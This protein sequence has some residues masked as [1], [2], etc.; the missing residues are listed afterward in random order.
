MQKRKIILKSAN[1]AR[2]VPEGKKY[3]NDKK[4]K[5]APIKKKVLKIPKNVKN[6]NNSKSML[7][8]S[9]T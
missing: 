6:T 8:K 5:K 2:K 3:K 7:K 4:F 1:Y 9:K